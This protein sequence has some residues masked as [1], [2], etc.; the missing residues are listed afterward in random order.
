MKSLLPRLIFCAGLLLTLTTPV[1][2]E[3]SSKQ[4]ATSTVPTDAPTHEADREIHRSTEYQTAYAQGQQE[5]QVNIA[6]GKPSIYTVGKPGGST[7]DEQ[8]GLPLV[9][10][11]GCVVD[12][13]IM[14]RKDGYNAQ[15][16]EWATKQSNTED[17]NEL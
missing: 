11:A 6:M 2:A 17:V 3:T 8:T 9:A 5:A 10:I 16:A 4:Y 12:D 15:I 7:V 13:S 14:G 1:V